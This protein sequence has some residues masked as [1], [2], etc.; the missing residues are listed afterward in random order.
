MRNAPRQRRSHNVKKRLQ[1]RH[2]LHQLEQIFE[3]RLKSKDHEPV[4]KYD[5]FLDQKLLEPYEFLF[6]K[7]ATDQEK[8]W[9]KDTPRF[10]NESASGK[11]S[12]QNYIDDEMNQ[13]SLKN[14]LVESQCTIETIQQ[15]TPIAEITK[16][17]RIKCSD[18]N[19]VA[20]P[21]LKLQFSS[22]PIPQISS[23]PSMKHRRS[24]AKS[25]DR[26]PGSTQELEA[27]VKDTGCLGLLALN[28]A[29]ITSKPSSDP[30]I[31]GF[32]T[33]VKAQ[34]IAPLLAG[35][36]ILNKKAVSM[37][38]SKKTKEWSGCESLAAPQVA[39]AKPTRAEDESLAPPEISLLPR[40]DKNASPSAK[41]SALYSK[42]P[43][44]PRKTKKPLK[45][46]A[47]MSATNFPKTKGKRRSLRMN[48]RIP[49][50][51]RRI[52]KNLSPVALRS[53]LLKLCV[54]PDTLNILQKPRNSN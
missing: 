41:N 51:L 16:V 10:E 22:L 31:D 4:K 17:S 13:K 45:T 7:R 24:A 53:M 6:D 2:P 14:P 21:I 30:A 1:S 18:R 35:A 33:H 38:V 34:S 47:T 23:S 25:R 3:R 27:Q 39:D 9:A 42:G 50:K 44:G 52:S 29:Q 43:K 19:K 26:K 28:M 54:G 48:T 15:S 40:T 37:N 5:K 46:V 8:S 12:I 11:S 36:L 20:K 32:K 49:A